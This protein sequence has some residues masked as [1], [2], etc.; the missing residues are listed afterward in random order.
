MFARK[1]HYC[2]I[3]NSALFTLLRIRNYNWILTGKDYTNV[4]NNRRLTFLKRRRNYDD[5]ARFREKLSC[6]HVYCMARKVYPRRPHALTQDAGV[7]RVNL[8]DV[9]FQ[10]STA[11]IKVRIMQPSTLWKNKPTR[12]RFVIIFLIFETVES[13]RWT[14][15]NL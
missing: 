10:V 5:Q 8:V 14:T 15:S 13:A 11:I 9:N 4:I 2:K 3:N 12:K 7:R 6:I 1:T